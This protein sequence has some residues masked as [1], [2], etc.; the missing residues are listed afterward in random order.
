MLVLL[1][2]ALVIIALVVIFVAIAVVL[3]LIAGVMGGN[4]MPLS[5][6]SQGL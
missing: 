4:E 3:P 5:R 1:S 6:N 2:I